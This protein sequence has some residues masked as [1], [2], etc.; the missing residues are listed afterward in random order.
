MQKYIRDISLAATFFFAGGVGV[1]LGAMYCKMELG[2]N[3]K[4]MRNTSTDVFT[5]GEGRLNQRAPW[6]GFSDDN[7]VQILSIANPGNAEAKPMQ[8][9]EEETS[10][11][12]PWLREMARQDLKQARPDYCF[13]CH[14]CDRDG[15]V[16]SSTGGRERAGR[17]GAI[18]VQSDSWLATVSG[19]QKKLAPREEDREHMP[20]LVLNSNEGNNDS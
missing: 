9:N 19:K 12:K 14:S 17:S 11:A 7:K 16:S 3:K 6:W 5:P 4:P 1:I 10:K 15:L 8:L 2:N 18:V 20:W 13:V